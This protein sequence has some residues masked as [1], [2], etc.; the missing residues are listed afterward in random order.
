MF[1]QELMKISFKRN[2]QKNSLISIRQCPFQ[3]VNRDIYAIASQ[4]SYKV[5]LNYMAQIKSKVEFCFFE[6]FLKMFIFIVFLHDFSFHDFFYKILF[7][8]SFSSRY[9][10]SLNQNMD[11]FFWKLDFRLFC[12]SLFNENF[13]G[14]YLTNI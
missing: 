6:L 4:I 10:L 2:G 12:V 8:S 7:F 5:L 1:I 14:F 3:I 9:I 13:C 11:T